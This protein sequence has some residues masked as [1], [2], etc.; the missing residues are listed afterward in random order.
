MLFSA[1]FSSLVQYFVVNPLSRWPISHAQFRADV[2]AFDQVE[3]NHRGVAKRS[4][5]A[6]YFRLRVDSEG[7]IAFITTMN[8]K[9]IHHYESVRF[10]FQGY[11]TTM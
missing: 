10:A 6:Y 2:S 1:K 3:L 5:Y 11:M 8:E 9:I 7:N 4:V